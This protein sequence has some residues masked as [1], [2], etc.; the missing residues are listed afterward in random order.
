MSLDVDPAQLTDASG[1]ITG[2][3]SGAGD[4]KLEDIASGGAETFGHDGVFTAISGFCSTWQLAVQ[5]LQQRATSAA[6]LLGDAAKSF[7]EQDANAQQQ[8]QNQ[9][10]QMPGGQ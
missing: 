10:Q 4:M 1:K 8:V 9:Q 5:I 3:V 7:G 2:A 6:G